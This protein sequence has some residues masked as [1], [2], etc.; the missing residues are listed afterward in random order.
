[1]VVPYTFEEN[2]SLTGMIRWAIIATIALVLSLLILPLMHANRGRHRQPA[3]CGSHE[4]RLHLA[5]QRLTVFADSAARDKVARHSST[6]LRSTS[7]CRDVL[8]PHEGLLPA[9]ELL[10]RHLPTGKLSKC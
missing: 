5:R 1:M 2:S 9:V 6:I 10:M 4:Y 3:D 8:A 7:Q